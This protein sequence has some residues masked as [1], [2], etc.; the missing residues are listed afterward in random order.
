MTFSVAF[1]QYA[2]SGPMRHEEELLEKG[3]RRRGIPIRYYSVKRIHR[4]QLPLGPETFIAGDMDAMHGAMK[5]LRIPVPQPDDYPESLREFLRRRVWT[6]TL[7]EIEHAVENGS[8]PA[9]FVKPSERRKSFTGA[10]CYSERD[11]AAF[12]NVSRRQRVWC[13]E[14]VTWVA[15]YRVYVIDGRVIGVDR[16]DGDGSVPLDMDV[17]ESAIATYHRSGTA[18]SAYGIDFGVLTNG[19]TA[20]VEAND[21]YALGAYDIAADQ[22]TELVLRRWRELVDGARPGSTA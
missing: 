7:G 16:Y 1:L 5:Q 19:E 17:V 4:R 11:F 13:S 14:V 10:L 15:E 3:L 2:G 18:P 22:Y 21:G 12:G 8:A 20:L 9:V 6:S